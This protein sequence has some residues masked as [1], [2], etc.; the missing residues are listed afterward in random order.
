MIK[1]IIF[2]M[3]GL[4]IDSEPF[5]LKAYNKVLKEFGQFLTDENNQK[6]VGT[7]DANV[8]KDLI[9]KY[10]LP[11]SQHEL[12]QR[13]NN[14][15]KLLFR[16]N[17]LP[18]EGLIEL[19]NNLHKNNYKIAIASGSHIDEIDIVLTKLKIKEYFD[20]I[21]SSDEVENGKPAPDV[22]LYVAS[23]LNI[24]PNKCLVLEDS[25]NG[26]VAA[27]NAGMK[28]Y[29]IPSRETKNEVFNLADRILNSLND[30]YESIKKD[31]QS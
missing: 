15:Y 21:V 14:E 26:E 31:Y 7:S 1:A 19:I 17:I 6:Y 22:F 25:H 18:Q 4:M 13:K 12:K 28:C 23:R 8:C 20:E 30:V 3:D 24:N 16:K 5:H 27:K 9:K 29:I 11:I 2:D 10:G